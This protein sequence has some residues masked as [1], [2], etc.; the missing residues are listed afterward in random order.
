VSPVKK[1]ILSEFCRAKDIDKLLLQE[2]THEGFGVCNGYT[3]HVNVGTEQRGTAILISN[4]LT[5]DE[6]DVLPSGRGIAGYY[7]GTYIV[8][9]YAPSGAARRAEREEFSNVELP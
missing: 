5:M 2:V 1:E 8:N 9:I 4:H 7:Q 6:I 3:A